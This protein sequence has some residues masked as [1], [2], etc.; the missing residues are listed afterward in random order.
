MQR[1]IKMRFCNQLQSYIVTFWDHTM[2]CKMPPLTPVEWSLS[3]TTIRIWEWRGGNG[4]LQS[5]PQAH[6]TVVV[7]GRAVCARVNNTATLAD[8]QQYCL[9][10]QATTVKTGW[11]LWLF[12][13]LPHA[14]EPPV[15][16]GHSS[17]T[18]L[19]CSVHKGIFLQLWRHLRRKKQFLSRKIVTKK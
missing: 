4:P 18:Q 1:N 6:W 9:T 5:W 10:K 8:L 12:L 17:H 19:C 2:S 15:F 16:S 7:S 14:I 3:D 11:V 13:V